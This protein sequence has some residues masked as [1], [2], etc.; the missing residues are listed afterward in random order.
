MK[1]VFLGDLLE[2]SKSQRSPARDHPGNLS[3][4]LNETPSARILWPARH[5]PDTFLVYLAFRNVE[6]NV[7]LSISGILEILK[8]GF[9]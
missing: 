2:I 3:L 4:F 5:S 9:S 8:V 1:N 6:K 7:V